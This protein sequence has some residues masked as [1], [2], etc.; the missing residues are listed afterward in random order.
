MAANKDD[1][2]SQ[3]GEEGSAAS[4]DSKAPARVLLTPIPRLPRPIYR[5]LFGHAIKGEA[6]PYRMTAGPDP[7]G[8]AA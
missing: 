3:D 7:V 8:D 4:E 2:E 6:R 1:A 5:G